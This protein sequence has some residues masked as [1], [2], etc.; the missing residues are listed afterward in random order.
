M[1]TNTEFAKKAYDVAMGVYGKT[2]YRRDNTADNYGWQY[3]LLTWYN[4]HWCADCIGFIKA[5]VNGWSAN[6]KVNGGGMTMDGYQD[7]TEAGL[8]S[9]CSDRSKDFSKLTVGEYLYMDGHGGI[10]IGEKTVNGKAYNVAECT[11]S[12]GGGCLLSYVASD[13][14]R[15]NHRGGSYSCKWQEHGK[16]NRIKYSSSSSGSGTSG[17]KSTTYATVRAYEDLNKLWLAE[18]NNTTTTS[19]Y[20]GIYGSDIDN[21]MLKITNGGTVKYRVHTWSGD[22]SEKYP[23]AGKWLPSVTGYSANDH[24][25]GYAGD[26]TPI[27]G[28]CI[29]S[30][31]KEIMY[32]VHMRKNGE[33]LPWVSSKKGNIKDATNGFAGIIGM[34]IDAIEVKFKA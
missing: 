12:W 13:G 3:N 22:A 31:S 7:L 29:E 14:G 28:F 24:N 11:M 15:Y 2:T 9:T 4:N 25:N 23:N 21:V 5:L 30:A 16:L 27:D 19:D 6:K 17:K 10:Y 33:W 34:P 8:L 26:N 1:L 20:A 32:R 18:V